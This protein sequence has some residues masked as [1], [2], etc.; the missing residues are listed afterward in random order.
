MP[1]MDNQK[2]F[3]KALRG[4]AVVRP[5]FW[6]MRQAGRYLPEYLAVRRDA[7]SFLDLVYNPERAAEVTLQPLRRFGMDAAILFSDIL[8]V[9]Q[10]LGRRVTFEAGEG[11]RLDPLRPG[12]M[13]PRLAPISMLCCNRFMRRSQ[14]SARNWYG[15]GFTGTAL[16]GFAGAPWTIACYMAEGGGSRDFLAARHW[17][18]LTRTVLPRWLILSLTPLSV[19]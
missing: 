6:L 7:G 9:P 11:P 1:G 5:P 3:L 13:L 17:R 19:I 16:I 15:E 8:T 10:A 18:H 14:P 2:L 4:E 12:D